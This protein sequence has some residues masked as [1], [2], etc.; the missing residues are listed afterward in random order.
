M[1]LLLRIMPK[2]T[3]PNTPHHPRRFRDKRQCCPLLSLVENK[4]NT[5]TMTTTAAVEGGSPGKR[6][7]GSV[8]VRPCRGKHS[9]R[10]RA[11]PVPWAGRWE[12]DHSITVDDY[13]D[14]DGADG[15]CA[16]VGNVVSKGPELAG[17]RLT[18]PAPVDVN[19]AHLSLGT[20]LSIVRRRAAGDGRPSPSNTMRTRWGTAMQNAGWEPSIS[21]SP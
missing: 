10:M 13:N 8:S 2:G 6:W 19:K 21:S 16:V 17:G 14:I 12:E 15:P 5:I 18:T 11:R 7:V 1:S 20:A 4:I 9:R 3:F